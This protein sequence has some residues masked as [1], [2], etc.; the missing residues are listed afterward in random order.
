M[1]TISK[2]IALAGAAA[3]LP[4]SASADIDPNLPQYERVA[5]VS[6]TL[7]SVG[8]NTLTVVL[9]LLA[10]G[11]E[12][13]YPN[14]NIQIQGAGSGTAPAALIDGTAQIG[15][16]SRQMRESER[17]AFEA[18]YGYQPTEIAIA[19]DALAVFV[20]RDNPIEGLSLPE[21]DAMFSSTNRLGHRPIR[22]WGQAGLGGEWANQRV[23]VYGRNSVSGTYGVFR[24]LALGGG[25]YDGARYQ[26]MPG[27]SAVTQAIGEDRFGIGYSGIGYLT[28]DTR[29]IPVSS[30]KG[31]EFFEPNMANCLSGDYPI[32]RLLYLY[33]N[34]NPRE[35]IDTL[36]G[37]FL[38]YVLSLQ[39]QE[40]VVR[41]GFFPLPASVVEDSRGQ[42]R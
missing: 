3:V 15:P 37:E 7:N 1:K 31:G 14:V 42:L 18:R 38:N 8:S 6:G 34:K 41:A 17:D 9:Q 23:S 4:F 25:D 21:I 30:E 27:S 19:I 13:V 5:G 2:I 16:M 12:S 40:H 20:H 33:V 36:T 35:E 24:N 22:T 39:G 32:F 28:A 10:E 11:F 26:E 29:A